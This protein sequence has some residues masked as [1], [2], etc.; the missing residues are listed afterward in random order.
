MQL[1]AKIHAIPPDWYD[2]HREAICE[3]VPL[4]REA[5]RDSHCWV[6]GSRSFWFAPDGKNDEWVRYFVTT[7]EARASL[8]KRIYRCR[9]L[10]FDLVYKV[11][12]ATLTISF[13][14]QSKL[15]T[16]SHNTE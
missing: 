9:G 14:P 13:D 12:N 1:L 8:T 15:A 7:N 16:A 11:T 10:H 5:G 4:F 6:S 3:R 2:P